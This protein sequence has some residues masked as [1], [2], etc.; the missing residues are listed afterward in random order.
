[1][2]KKVELAKKQRA[3]LEQKY[4]G[5]ESYFELEKTLERMKA[6]EQDEVRKINERTISLQNA[7]IKTSIEIRE[8]NIIKEFEEFKKLGKTNYDEKEEE[9][10]KSIVT[11][12]ST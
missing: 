3:E 6:S 2:R 4:I 10:R 1:M 9:I 5:M 8:Q 7:L 11:E 12:T